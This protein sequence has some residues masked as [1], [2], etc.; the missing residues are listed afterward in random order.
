MKRRVTK[1][2]LKVFQI[3]TRHPRAQF[4]LKICSR[5]RSA[6]VDP[7]LPPLLKLMVAARGRVG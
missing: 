2:S 6:L 1:F 7:D 5:A 4:I 3:D